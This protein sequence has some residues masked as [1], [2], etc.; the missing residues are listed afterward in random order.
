MNK[1]MFVSENIH[2]L[3][4]V[5]LCFIFVLVDKYVPKWSAKYV[6]MMPDEKDDTL[7]G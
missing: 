5:I 4:C 1:L 6:T 2:C 3:K 7:F